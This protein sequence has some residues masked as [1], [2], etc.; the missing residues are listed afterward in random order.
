MVM[1]CFILAG[2]KSERMGREKSLLPLAGKPIVQHM[3]ERVAPLF[4]HLTIITNHPS[5]YAFLERSIVGDAIPEKGPLGGIYSG[6]LNLKGSHG[7]FLS[8]DLPFLSPEVVRYLR[9]QVESFDV[10]VPL[11]E[12]GV[13][14]LCAIYSKNCLLP[15]HEQLKQ[16]NLKIVDFFPQV[17]VKEIGLPE[18]IHFDPFGLSFFNVN[19]KEDY[20]RAQK[21]W[22]AM[23]FQI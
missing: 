12:R 18:L 14:P 2:G 15:I 4:D 21:L 22:K 6:L 1:E 3:I 8:C 9:D 16:G 7:F 10:V 23:R 17:R 13:E 5:N 11:T 19:T 20:E